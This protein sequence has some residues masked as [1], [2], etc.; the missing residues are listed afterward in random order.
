MEPL[1]DIAKT[2]RFDPQQWR[3]SGVPEGRAGLLIFDEGPF[4]H[5]RNRRFCQPCQYYACR[6]RDVGVRRARRRHSCRTGS[7]WPWP[8]ARRCLPSRW[9]SPLPSLALPTSIDRQWNAT[10]VMSRTPRGSQS[11]R[12]RRPAPQAARAIE[13]GLDIERSAAATQPGAAKKVRTSRPMGWPFQA[14]PGSPLGLALRRQRKG[15]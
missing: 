3:P 10:G 5:R 7:A 12:P 8:P 9:R 1:K 14:A 4:G 2:D 13:G 15:R 6:R 11:G